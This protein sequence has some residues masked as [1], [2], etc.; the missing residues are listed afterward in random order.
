M[1][2]ELQYQTANGP[3]R[4]YSLTREEEKEIAE[5]GSDFVATE[6]YGLIQ[7]ISLL[8]AMN[9]KDHPDFFRANSLIWIWVQMKAD[10]VRSNVYILMAWQKIFSINELAR[11]MKM[12]PSF[13]GRM[14]SL[15]KPIDFGGWNIDTL[16]RLSITLT[17][18]PE[19]LLQA[20]LKHAVA[21]E[22]INWQI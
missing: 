20:D 12:N 5:K 8:G 16:F 17:A 4:H 6:M 1:T 11:R 13:I 21:N 2:K 7:D 22:V 15:E 19:L 10:Q 3:R 14:L 18:R 9:Y